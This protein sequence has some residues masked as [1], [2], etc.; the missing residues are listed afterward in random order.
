L[1]NALKKYEK[2]DLLLPGVTPEWQNKGVHSLY[3]AELNKN[4]NNLGVKIAITNPQLESNEAHRIW[5][6]YDCKLLIRRRIYAKV[7]CY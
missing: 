6:K 3:H 1:L 7:I 4:Y 5:L 2:I